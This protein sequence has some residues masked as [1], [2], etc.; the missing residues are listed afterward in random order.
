MTFAD[1]L[2]VVLKQEGGYCNNPKDPGGETMLGITRRTWEAFTGKPAVDMR[3]LTP[4]QVAP[5][6]RMMY[7]LPLHCDDLSAPVALCLFDMGVNAGPVRAVRLLQ[8]IVGGLRDGEYGP[9]TAAALKAFLAKNGT[10]EFVRQ[11]TNARRDYYRALG[12]FDTFGKGWLRRCDA[13]E[14]EALKVCT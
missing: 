5:I 11:F 2:A 10:A 1:A 12:T 7:W 4:A 3:A 9:K 8:T 6:Y 13:V 14:T